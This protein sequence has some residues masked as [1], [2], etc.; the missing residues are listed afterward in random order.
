MTSF[1]TVLIYGTGILLFLLLLVGLA[2]VAA[3]RAVAWALA[4]A[5]G[6]FD[7]TITDHYQDKDPET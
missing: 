3:F 7:Q 4:E 2:C 6:W 1:V 5:E